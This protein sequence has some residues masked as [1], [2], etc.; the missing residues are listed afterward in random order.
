MK[1]ESR[2]ENLKRAS[3]V[4]T[5]IYS[6]CKNLLTDAIILE[7]IKMM[8]PSDDY[9]PEQAD[10]VLRNKE[11]FR[12]KFSPIYPNGTINHE[13]FKGFRIKNLKARKPEY[14]DFM[15]HVGLYLDSKSDSKNFN[16]L[17]F[18]IK[19]AE[20]GEHVTSWWIGRLKEDGTFTLNKNLVFEYKELNQI[21]NSVDF[22]KLYVHK[23]EQDLEIID[24]DEE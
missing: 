10:F 15:S 23:D 2:I 5:N 12:D 24:N 7:S 22:S 11:I 16:K 3:D 9:T 20:T 19:D 4:L 18:A 13:F 1:Y 14:K 8:K 6:G 17:C 21:Y